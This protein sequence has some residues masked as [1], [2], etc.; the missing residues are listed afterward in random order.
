MSRCNTFRQSLVV[1]GFLAATSAFA[2]ETPTKPVAEPTAASTSKAP[3]ARDLIC[4]DRLR[5][6]SHIAMRTC[7]TAEQWAAA[8]RMPAAYPQEGQSIS[9]VGQSVGVSAFTHSGSAYQF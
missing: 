5:P 1:L 3:E 7:A 4:R 2:D 9:T 8:N 6:G